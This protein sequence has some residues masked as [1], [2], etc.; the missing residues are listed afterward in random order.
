[1][2]LAA[3][4]PGKRHA[5][6]HARIVLQQPSTSPIAGSATQ[7]AA[8]AQ[9]ILRDRERLVDILSRH[10]GRPKEQVEGEIERDYHMTPE[11]AQAWGVIDGIAGRT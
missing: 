3:G 1:V 11:Q 4:A 9:Q 10:C 2:L 6:A 7:V 5:L 8:R